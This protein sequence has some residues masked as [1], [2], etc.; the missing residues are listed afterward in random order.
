MYYCTGKIDAVLVTPDDKSQPIV[1]KVDR[2]HDGRADLIFFDFK[3]R[4][5]W[6]LSWWDE[7]FSGEWTLVAYHDEETGLPSRW[8]SFEAYKKRLA[9]K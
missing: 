9:T 3:R 4:S 7:D 6:E 2:N 5:K 8:E 1:L